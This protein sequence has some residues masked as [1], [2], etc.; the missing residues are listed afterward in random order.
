[1]EEGCHGGHWCSFISSYE[2]C[3]CKALLGG[4]T[5]VQ[6]VGHAK[7]VNNDEKVDDDK[8]VSSDKKLL[9]ASYSKNPF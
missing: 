5:Y 9:R 3:C 4:I 2:G 1:M 7:K 8:R 6:K